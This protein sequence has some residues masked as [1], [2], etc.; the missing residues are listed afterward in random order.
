MPDAVTHWNEVLLDVVRNV[1][2]APGPISRGGAMVHGAI[3]DAVN[4]IVPSTHH[5]YLVS[6]PP[7]AGASIRAAV[8]HAAHDTLKAAFPTTTVDLDAALASAVAGISAPAVAGRRHRQGGGRG[9]DAARTA[10]GA[11][12]SSPYTP[13]SQPGDWRPTGSGNAATPYWSDVKPWGIPHGAAFRP[14][15]PGGYGTKPALLQSSEYAAQVN[16]VKRLGKSNSVDRTA[17]QTEIAWFWANDLNGT[18]KPPGHLIHI[19]QVVS[20]QRPDP[21]RERPT[22]GRHLRDGGRRNRG[23]GRQVRDEPRPVATRVGDPPRRL[24]EQRGD[25]ARPD[26]VPLSRNP[27]TNTRF[28]PPFPAYI[29]GHA[30]FGAAHAAV[31]RRTSGRTT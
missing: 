25:G 15:R 4:S 11:D 26:W 12:D 27:A 16:E 17:E 19:T 3:Y 22:S 23:V 28:T 30:T 8:A 6:V 9:D 10:D 14:P 5:P 20:D 1:G 21:R 13:G 7:P 29:S 2:G 18:Y 31:M 24:D